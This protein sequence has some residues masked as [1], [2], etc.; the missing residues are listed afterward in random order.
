MA[1]NLL[2]FLLFVFIITVRPYKDTADTVI[3]AISE[4]FLMVAQS[5]IA[6]LKKDDELSDEGE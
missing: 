2:N 6:I 3:A 1:I 4:L 5:V